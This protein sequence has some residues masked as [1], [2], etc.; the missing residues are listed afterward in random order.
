MITKQPPSSMP[1]RII[2]V[3]SYPAMM[4]KSLASKATF[5]LRSER[6]KQ[7][8]NEIL[9]TSGEALRAAV[10]QCVDQLE[11]AGKSGDMETVFAQAHEIRG[12]AAT[13]GMAMV[14][15]IANGLCRYLDASEQAGIKVDRSL[16]A[17]H[18]DAIIRASRS[19][20]EANK[21]GSV[22]AN[23]LAQLVAKK[24]DGVKD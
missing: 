15:Q 11:D 6:L 9:S 21:L 24:L 10:L 23:E 5:E 7:H 4:R 8:A 12:M 1:G 22:V 19:Q 14:G 16:V 17:L 20:D 3:E 2:P 18:L 13:A